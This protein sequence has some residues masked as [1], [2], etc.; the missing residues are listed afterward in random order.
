MEYTEKLIYFEMLC[1][2][3]GCEENT[4]VSKELLE[5]Y[6][7]RLPKLMLDIW[8]DYGLTSHGSGEIWFTNPDD[9][10]DIIKSYFGDGY[11]FIVYA[12]HSFGYLYA[13]TL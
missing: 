11:E 10:Q 13:I 1:E 9:F 3:H 2:E 8:E 7:D 5:K 6:K 12:R 4:T